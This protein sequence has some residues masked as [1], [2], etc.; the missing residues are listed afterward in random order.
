MAKYFQQ[1]ATMEKE[2]ERVGK[3]MQTIDICNCGIFCVIPF[4]W[5]VFLI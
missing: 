3:L 1:L 4:V 2:K 5:L